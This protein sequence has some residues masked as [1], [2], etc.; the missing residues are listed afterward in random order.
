VTATKLPK[1]RARRQRE[2]DVYAVPLG[3]LGFGFGRICASFDHAY[4]DVLA[5]EL[6]SLDEIVRQ[7]IIFRVSVARDAIA[8][9]GWQILGNVPLSRELALPGVYRHQPVGSVQAFRHSA[10]QSVPAST[11]ELAPLEALA[12]WFP[13]HI[14]GR[15]R[16]HFLNLPDPT[17]ESLR[18]ARRRRAG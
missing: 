14:E 12:T 3:D 16:N 15:L 4:Y 2:G 1:K 6:L 8:A 10:G 5:N 11:E 18:H 13:M 9:G 17:V 7:P